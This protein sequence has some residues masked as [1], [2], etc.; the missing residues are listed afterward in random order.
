M[1][2]TNAG[3][4]NKQLPNSPV[5]RDNRD[6]IILSNPNSEQQFIM[7]PKNNSGNKCFNE[8]F[9]KEQHIQIKKDQIG[10]T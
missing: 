8:Y 9:T 2:L 3:I 4:L 7:S 10:S 1:E 5:N 6:E